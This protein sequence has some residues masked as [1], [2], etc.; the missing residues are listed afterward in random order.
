MKG[1]ALGIP[2]LGK[3]IRLTVEGVFVFI[4]STYSRC[5]NAEDSNEACRR[6]VRMRSLLTRLFLLPPLPKESVI[7]FHERTARR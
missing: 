7:L 2:S 4:G 3:T 6:E 5:I 1:S